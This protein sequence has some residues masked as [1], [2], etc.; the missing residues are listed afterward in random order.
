[1]RENLIFTGIPESEVRRGEQENCEAIIREFLKSEMNITPDIQFDRVHRLGR[2]QSNQQNPRPII[3]KFTNY[4]DKELVR[5]SAPKTLI[6]TR[7]GVNEQFPP[8]IENR[9]KLLYAEAKRARKNKENEVKLVRDRLFINGRQFVPPH[10]S[11]ENNYNPLSNRDHQVPSGS[12]QRNSLR[13]QPGVHT[14]RNFNDGQQQQERQY[15]KPH[16]QIQTDWNRQPRR[17]NARHGSS[18]SKVPWFGARTFVTQRNTEA[19]VRNDTHVFNRFTP[20]SETQSNETPF[21]CQSNAGKKKATSPLDAELNTKKQKES[22]VASNGDLGSS[23]LMVTAVNE[24][25]KPPNRVNDYPPISCSMTENVMHLSPQS[26]QGSAQLQMPTPVDSATLYYGPTV[27]NET[28]THK[29]PDEIINN[30]DM[31]VSAEENREV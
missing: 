13:Q 16:S 27:L 21:R 2:Y 30:S 12:D 10:N 3:A 1:M 9:R 6:G 8:E 28:M 20:L 26:T 29:T 23:P 14:N 11:N 22:N 17:N 4:K 18:A 15:Y 19:V 24:T 31:S 25:E 5:Q 7:Y